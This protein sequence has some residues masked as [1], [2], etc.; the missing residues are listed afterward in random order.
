MSSGVKAQAHISNLYYEP[1]TDGIGTVTITISYGDA[2]AQAIILVTQPTDDNV[3]NQIR[4]LGEALQQAVCSPQSLF[5]YPKIPLPGGSRSAQ[6]QSRQ[7]PIRTSESPVS[8]EP[9]AAGRVRRRSTLKLATFA[10]SE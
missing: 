4:S 10:E 8:S 5:S 3:L 1:G 9:P 6:R 2:E 7:D